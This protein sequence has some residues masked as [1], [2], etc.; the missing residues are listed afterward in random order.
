MQQKMRY[1]DFIKKLDHK[2]DR[3]RLG[4][5][6]N[7]LAGRGV[8]F[9]T[10]EYGYGI[11]VVVDLG[12]APK[13][14]GIAS[15][16]DKMESS[17][18]A[19]DNGSAIAVCLNIIE[20]FTEIK[21]AGIGLRIFFFDDEE[22][23][24]KGSAAYTR[25]FGV[26]DLTGLINME[27]VG[28]GDRFALWPLNAQSTG[29][30]LTAFEH[31]AAKAGISTSRFDNIITNTADH[32]SFRNAGLKDAF[33]VTCISAADITAATAYYDAMKRGAGWHALSDIL[34]RAPVFTHY[35]QPTDT[36][37]R[38]DENALLR[39]AGVIWDTVTAK[40]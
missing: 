9:R 4:S 8:P 23:G 36:A 18:G 19:N 25:Q 6:T 35:H 32:L 29:S 28:V 38:L 27:L 39:T 26:E 13:R 30:L 34:S 17:G 11:N 31:T 2:S 24:L 40:A 5:I 7:W 14:T 3:H 21:P 33:T 37:D 15:H 10:Q 1:T 22:T 12:D 20:R 16:F